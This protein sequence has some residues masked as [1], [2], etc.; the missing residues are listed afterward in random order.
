[1]PF[2]DRE[3]ITGAT[4][5]R[6]GEIIGA[7]SGHP[8]DEKTILI[9]RNLARPLPGDVRAY[10][11]N[12]GKAVGDTKLS[13]RLYE[14]D[15]VLV[16][17]VHLLLREVGKMHRRLSEKVS[18]SMSDHGHFRLGDNYQ[19][20]SQKGREPKISPSQRAINQWRQGE[21]GF[22][23]EIAISRHKER[24][25]EEIQCGIAL[26][27]DLPFNPQ[28]DARGYLPISRVSLP[29]DAHL[30]RIFGSQAS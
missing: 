5:K 20:E 16:A 14:E 21:R 6:L 17:L 8:W 22:T 4:A 24:G 29:L 11:D 27:D 26:R 18:L 28:D 10:L 25:I 7:G 19:L 2:T 12:R 13:T 9:V 1:M 3:K 15:Q 30:E 23:F